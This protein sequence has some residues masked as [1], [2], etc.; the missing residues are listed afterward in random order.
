MRLVR[1]LLNPGHKSA[2]IQQIIFIDS[3]RIT[4]TITPHEK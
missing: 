3:F 4:E 1:I 2:I